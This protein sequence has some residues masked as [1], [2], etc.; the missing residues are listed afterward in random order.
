MKRIFVQLLIAAFALTTA[1]AGSVKVEV[2]LAEDKDSK[3]TTKFEADVPEI[4]AFFKTTGTKK[5]DSLRAVWIGEDVIGAAKNTKINEKSLSAEGED[6]FGSFSM[7][8]P[9]KGWPVGKYRVDFYSGSEVVTTAKFQVTAAKS[10]AADEADDTHSDAAADADD[11]DND[12]AQYSFKVHNTT[13]VR[14]VKLLASEDGKDFSTFDIGIGV[15][16]GE[17]MTL[18]WDKSTNNS[19]CKWYIKAVYADDSL[20]KVAKIDFCEEDLILDF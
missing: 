10:E 7:T 15:D 8:K 9:T 13:E 6:F 19:H 11:D 4:F 1:S 14:I 2:K 3:P 12:D 5:G 20:S 17:T 18:N 16:A